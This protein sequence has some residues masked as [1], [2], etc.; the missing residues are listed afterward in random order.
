MFLNP[1]WTISLLLRHFEKRLFELAMAVIM[2][3]ESALL[4]SSPQSI[5]ES[6]FLYALEMISTETFFWIFFL[7][8]MARLI[9][10]TL[11]GHWMPW[12]A[13]LR[14]LGAFFGALMW[15]QWCA[16][17]FILNARSGMPISPDVPVYAVLAC[18]E[19]ISMYRAIL[20]AMKKNVSGNGRD[21]GA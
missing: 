15:A 2:L 17:L 6:A 5:S 1:E 19:I 10:I 4:F 11:N 8:G 13:V 21:D 16:A 14:C 3:A 18:F 9:A 20:G 7:F 12:G